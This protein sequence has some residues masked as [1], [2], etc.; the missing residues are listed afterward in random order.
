LDYLR[1]FHD[2]EQ[3]KHREP[4]KAFIPALSETIKGLVRLSADFIAVV[5]RLSPQSTAT[6]DMDAT[7]AILGIK[8]EKERDFFL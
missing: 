4:H 6:L 5:Q 7:I 3:E 8:R 2:E 1:L